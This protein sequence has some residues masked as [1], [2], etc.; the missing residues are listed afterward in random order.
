MKH[1]PLSSH[2]IGYVILAALAVVLGLA[3]ACISSS[4]L[5]KKLLRPT[6]L[7]LGA[8]I[9]IYLILRGIAEFWVINYSNPASYRLSWGGP[10]LIRCFCSSFGTGID[11]RNR[12]RGLAIQ[13][14]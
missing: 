12:N 7:A 1:H 8:I 4:K 10:S 6:Y 11:Y 13:S 14:S 3:I 9:A 5:R 2:I